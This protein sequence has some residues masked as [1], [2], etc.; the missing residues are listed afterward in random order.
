MTFLP[1]SWQTCRREYGAQSGAKHTCSH[2]PVARIPWDIRALLPLHLRSASSLTLTCVV[3][4]I[5]GLLA[6][7]GIHLALRSWC[8]GRL[9]GPC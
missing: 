5:L 1:V 6:P 8:F 7:Q 2:R 9:Q 4:G 3:E